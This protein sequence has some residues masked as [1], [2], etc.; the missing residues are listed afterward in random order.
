[1]HGTMNIKFSIMFSIFTVAG[2]SG[3][4]YDQSRK[5]SC[6]YLSQISLFSTKISMNENCIKILVH[7]LQR[8]RNS[9][10]LCVCG[11]LTTQWKPRD[12]FYK[13]IDWI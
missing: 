11:K 2:K 4:L 10:D 5:I 7:K 8:E 12:I 3:L 13:R 6:K 1:M 9:D